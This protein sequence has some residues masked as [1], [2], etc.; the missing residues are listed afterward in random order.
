[1]VV[2]GWELNQNWNP[3]ELQPSQET[4][5]NELAGWIISKW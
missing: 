2:A 4:K 5:N 1:M 3:I